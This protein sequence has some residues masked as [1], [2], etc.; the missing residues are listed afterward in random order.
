MCQILCKK[1]I[2]IFRSLVIFNT[3]IFFRYPI[4]VNCK[5]HDAE[6]NKKIFDGKLTFSSQVYNISGHTEL[7]GSLFTYTYIKLTPQN[8]S[9]PIIFE[10]QVD[11][12]SINEFDLT[13]YIQY[14]GKTDR[15]KAH[16]LAY[17]VLNW[18]F[19]MQVCI[20]F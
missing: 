16:L 2:I 20:Y 6:Q 11:P 7:I 19:N 5:I 3:I 9:F 12:K 17:Q 4:T 18:N 13:G 10:Y 14:S 1:S 15:F 8:N